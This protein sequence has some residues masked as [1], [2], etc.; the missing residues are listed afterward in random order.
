MVLTKLFV[1]RIIL[2]QNNS[3]SSLLLDV[4]AP[5]CRLGVVTPPAGHSD[6]WPIKVSEYS[7]EQV[8]KFTSRTEGDEDEKEI[9][10]ESRVH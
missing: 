7:A 9:G 10:V 3:I 6:T 4:E 5:F 2:A 1:V 8:N